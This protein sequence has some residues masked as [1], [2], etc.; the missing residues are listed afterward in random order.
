MIPYACP[1][2]NTVL[3][4]PEEF[5]GK[6]GKCRICGQVITV[7]SP[8]I[9]E[10]E[11]AN[12]YKK[13]IRKAQRSRN[14]S[15]AIAFVIILSV[16]IAYVAGL[17]NTTK[18]I[19]EGI[20]TNAINASDSSY[21]PD[22]L[23]TIRLKESAQPNFIA[24]TKQEEETITMKDL[25]N[26]GS[27]NA[28]E[29]NSNEETLIAENNIEPFE[30]KGDRL[31]MSLEEFKAKY[32]RVVEGHN[33]WAPCCSDT[34]A[35]NENVMLLS[36]PWHFEAGIVTCSISFP[37]EIF[38]G[39][40]PTIAEVKVKLL[41]HH[42]IDGKLYQITALIPHSGYLDVKN[43]MIAKYGMPNITSDDEYQNRMGARFTGESLFWTNDVSSIRLKEY[44]GKLDI[45][46]LLFAH[47]AL[48][49]IAIARFPEPT[50]DDL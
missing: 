1:K 5:A 12:I 42:F 29:A 13:E 37:F 9:A 18:M 35:S 3:Q 33:E 30:L 11:N 40:G 48:G 28:P 25:S 20:T 2:C 7:P 34:Q 8:A 41:V 43:G 14:L 44:D 10:D 49:A 17:R 19:A 32:T 31:G 6:E 38:R 16:P 24:S 27:D 22:A 45:S 26:G 39:E 4:I 15:L 46:S 36:K 21:S 23:S 50:G 47:N